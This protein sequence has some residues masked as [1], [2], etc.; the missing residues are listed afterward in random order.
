MDGW[1]LPKSITFRLLVSI[2]CS[3][4]RNEYR[5]ESLVQD[6]DW[7]LVPTIQELMKSYKRDWL[8]QGSGGLIESQTMNIHS[9]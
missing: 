4:G 5:G 8:I 7:S 3:S 9:N 6:S 2:C 1:G